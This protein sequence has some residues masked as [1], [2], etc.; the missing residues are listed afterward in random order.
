MIEIKNIHLQ[1][2]DKV[3]LKNEQLNINEGYIYVISGKSG[4]GKTTL[5]YVI[6][7]LSNYS[8]TIY[9]WDDQQIDN[10][11]DEKIAMIRKN[12]IG[13][14]LQDLELISENLTL[15]DNIKC[16]FALI[17]KK[18]DW[19]KVDEYMHKMNLDGLLDQKIDELSRGQRQR[20]AL[21][22][23]LIKD[24]KLIILD[25]PTSS[26]DKDNTIKLMAYLQI[27]AKN[28]H[29]MI[30]IASHDRYV[31]NNC[32][33]LYEIEN[34]RLVLKT[35]SLIKENVS[36]LKN[37]TK[38]SNDFYKIYNKNNYKITKLL[39]KLIYMI[40]IIVICIG[41]AILTMYIN[42]I[43]QLYDQY[44]S[45]EIIVVNSDENLLNV[46]YDGK[47]NVFSIEQ[48]NMLKEIE[49]VIDVDYYWQL[50]GALSFGKDAKS[51]TVIPKK[52]LDKIAIPSSLANK[53]TKKMSLS[54]M[55]SVENQIYEFK[56]IIDDYIVK[57]Y[58][59]S[60]NIDNEVIFLPDKLIDKLLLQ[61]NIT[62]SA[63]L[64]VRCD[65]V[66][67]IENTMTKITNWLPEVTVLSNGTKYK[68]QLDNLQNIEQLIN[69]LRIVTIIGIIVIVYIIQI[70]ENKSRIK[71]ITNLRI[72]GITEKTFYKLYYYENRFVILAT[73]VGC[74]MGYIIAVS[75]FKSS[76][77]L[78]NLSLIL[79]QSILCL[80]ISQIIPLIISSKQIFTKDIAKILRDN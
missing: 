37:D 3:L 46:L 17:N 29:K 21:V 41:P 22:L 56:T 35:Q 65:N 28:Y 77:V 16:M 55:L 23:A 8:N 76:L 33:V 59:I 19:A 38:I 9:H 67:N 48:I 73:I 68:E 64:V 26:L 51:I 60:E 32:D 24:A 12:Q 2:Q 42:E 58:L 62:N 34:C 14:I 36:M 66:D 39:M 71:E 54:M 13:Y 31:K 78:S 79:L 10:L 5:L 57:D 53:T 74:V 25:E 63:S 7:L 1:I 80:L 40:M 27:I 44:A 61:Q 15:R 45:N 20:F 75:Y 30:V 4:C 70:M 69:L 18:D 47:A 43:K 50:E 6:S 11:S 49:H 72:N 52:D